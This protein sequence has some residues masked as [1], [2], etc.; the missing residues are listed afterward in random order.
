MT[1]T[2]TILG[3]I[4]FV[5]ISIFI[6]CNWFS[7]TE[8]GAITFLDYPN[9]LSDNKD[10]I[11]VTHINWACACPNW[12]P[13]QYIEDSSVLEDDY[14][15]Y[16]IFLESE[17]TSVKISDNYFIDEKQYKL[18]LIGKYYNDKGISRDY[19]KQ[20]SQKPEKARV[21]QYSHVEVLNN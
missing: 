12:L 5:L 14:S 16:C 17:N 2:A 18:R 9:K 15:D 6:I 10:T 3:S 13:I 4:C 11:T 20:T 8:E 7:D 21:F 19:I 1:K